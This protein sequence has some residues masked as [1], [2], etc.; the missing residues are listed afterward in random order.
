MK[1]SKVL[2]WVIAIVLLFGIPTAMGALS[3]TTTTTTTTAA[4][5]TTG[6]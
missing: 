3:T 6:S 5:T 1:R 2:V 4:T